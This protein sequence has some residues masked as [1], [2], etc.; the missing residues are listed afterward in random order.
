MLNNSQKEP[1]DEKKIEVEGDVV[2]VLPGL[3]YV[4]EI[5]FKGLK[6]KVKCYISGKMRTHFIQLAKGDRVRVEISLYDI[7]KG[8]ITY[9]LT[10]R[11]P[12]VGPPRRPKK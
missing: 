6:H 12:Q 10:K 8:R 9:R 5:D 2:E 11:N 3:E 7:D 4:V 1:T